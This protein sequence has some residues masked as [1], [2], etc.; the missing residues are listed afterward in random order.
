MDPSARGSYLEHPPEGAP[1]A[2]EAHQA[3]A[4]VGDTAPP[5]EVE[6]IDLNFV[7]FVVNGGQLHNWRFLV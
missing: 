4:A 7:T 3:A 5:S 2:R 6:E 1:L